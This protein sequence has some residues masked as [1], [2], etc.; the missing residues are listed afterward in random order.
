MPS[1]L[2]VNIKEIEVRSDCD[3]RAYWLE[4]INARCVG[5]RPL[6]VRHPV[7]FEDIVAIHEATGKVMRRETDNASV[8]AEDPGSIPCRPVSA[9]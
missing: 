8:V 9:E 1:K 2:H 5:G 4:M 3:Y 6:N 7:T